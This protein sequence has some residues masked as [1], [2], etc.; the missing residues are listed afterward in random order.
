MKN[1]A[2]IAIALVVAACVPNHEDVPLYRTPIAAQQETRYL[3]V[4]YLEGS[5]V[6]FNEPTL[7][8]S[9]L[10]QQQASNAGNCY[11]ELEVN[12][13]TGLVYENIPW[14]SLLSFEF[15]KSKSQDS[16]PHSYLLLLTSYSEKDKG[17][18][19]GVNAFGVTKNVTVTD[20]KYNG[21]LII[22][23]DKE[24]Y[25]N[26]YHGLILY[27]KNSVIEDYYKKSARNADFRWDKNIRIVVNGSI[28]NGNSGLTN[29]STTVYK[30][31]TLDDPVRSTNKYSFISVNLDSVL[32]IDKKTNRILAK[33]EKY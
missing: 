18:Y 21:I 20:G 30:T 10:N 9:Q 27:N 12:R 16:V 26:L 14:T 29:G 7:R 13:H 25:S 2:I 15:V 3:W 32:Y 8:F 4:S 5:E 22:P 1:L 11:I 23:H 17:G 33:L 31:P 24:S 19:L 6:F 28:Y